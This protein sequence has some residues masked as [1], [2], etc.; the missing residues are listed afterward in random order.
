MRSGRC[1]GHV[2]PAQ[3]LP[4]SRVL[5]MA[6]FPRA[7][8][9]FVLLAA[10][11][12]GCTRDES[13][14]ADF[15]N[16]RMSTLLREW[17]LYP[18]QLVFP[19]PGD[20]DD[21]RDF[22]RAAVVEVN[23]M[24]EA[25]ERQPD[26][27]SRLLPAT[28]FSAWFAGVREGFGFRVLA[29]SSADGDRLVL[30]D[31]FGQYPGEPPSPASEAGLGRGWRIDSIDG[32]QVAQ[33]LAEEGGWG[34]VQELLDQEQVTLGVIDP[35]GNR[36]DD[37]ALQRAPVAFDPV[38]RTRV[39]DTGSKKVGYFHLR[40]FLADAGFEQLRETFARFVA[41]D[42]RH[43]VI[44]LRYNTGGQSSM[45][46]Y[47]ANLIAGRAAEGA[48]YSRV[49]HNERKRSLD[50]EVHLAPDPSCPRDVSCTAAGV[51]LENV[52]E[53]VVL[54]TE[55][56]AS[57]SESLVAGLEPHVAVQLIGTRTSGKPVGAHGLRVCTWA[58]LPITHRIENAHGPSTYFDGLIPGC[59]AQD[60]L[61]RTF[62][63]P[64]EAMLAEALHWIERGVCTKE[65]DGAELPE[66]DLARLR[67]LRTP[68]GGAPFPELAGFIDLVD[69][70]EPCE[71]RL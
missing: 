5:P 12:S 24:P 6:R 14:D 42:V 50:R 29:E 19:A 58:F 22:L 37:R 33:L 20:H 48:L 40:D 34:R 49:V 60:D 2:G 38:V 53:V 71:G 1:P 25:S 30:T 70:R 10:T 61:S 46:H 41:E 52:E 8:Y 32:V 23:F 66:L 16:R 4:V 21:P 3:R 13:C 18:D 67:E 27:F 15:V 36:D 65:P 54:V 69:D 44:D 7:I 47:L 55:V 51:S 68:S 63:D 39:L 57:A 11:A 43:L 17:Y 28:Q 62:G 59:A 35:Q 45:A 26:V 56:T 64:E 31:V 9:S